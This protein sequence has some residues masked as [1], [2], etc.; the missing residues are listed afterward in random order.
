[1][2]IDSE[3]QTPSHTLARFSFSV[4][5]LLALRC[6]DSFIFPISL[7]LPFT[8]F[9]LVQA[10]HNHLSIQSRWKDRHTPN[11]PPNG[12]N[13]GAGWWKSEITYNLTLLRSSWIL[14]WMWTCVFARWAT[15]INTHANRSFSHT[16]T[17][18]RTPTLN[19]HLYLSFRFSLRMP[20]VS[21][22]PSVPYSTGPNWI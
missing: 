14:I 18:H 22:H 4:P 19:L 3:G 2:A 16:H 12:W 10:I 5:F 17:A 20:S 15:H 8:F 21:F 1:M 7:S 11:M 6:V 13:V 9:L